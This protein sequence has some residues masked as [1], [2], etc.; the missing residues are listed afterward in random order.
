MSYVVIQ[1]SISAV[2]RNNYRFINIII[3][4][5]RRAGSQQEI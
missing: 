5:F 1:I 2:E 4:F 3:C